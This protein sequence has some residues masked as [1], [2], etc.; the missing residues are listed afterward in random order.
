MGFW[1]IWIWTESP[2]MLWGD[3]CERLRRKRRAS[4]RMGGGQALD[5]V[6]AFRMRS[7]GRS[8]GR[9]RGFGAHAHRQGR[10]GWKR[11]GGSQGEGE[12]GFDP[13][14]SLW[15]R[16]LPRSPSPACVR[17]AALRPVQALSARRCALRGRGGGAVSPRLLGTDDDHFFVAWKETCRLR[18][19]TGRLCRAAT[20]FAADCGSEKL[21]K[22]TPLLTP[23]SFVRILTDRMGPNGAKFS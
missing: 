23:S 15:P 3:L 19:P 14:D 21:T 13:P 2:N 8:E 7:G 17:R 9:P 12:G 5:S 20:A 4:G 22:L 6:A 11:V 1:R 10:R 18:L 16:F